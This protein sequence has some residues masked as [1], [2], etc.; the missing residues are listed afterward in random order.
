MH[1]QQRQRQQ[2]RLGQQ[3]Q[4][5]IEANFIRVTPSNKIFFDEDQPKKK[6]LWWK[7]YKI[8]VLCYAA[9]SHLFSFFPIEAAKKYLCF[10]NMPLCVF[11]WTKL[12]I[13]HKCD[14]GAQK[15]HDNEKTIISKHF[16]LIF[17]GHDWCTWKKECAFNE[18]IFLLWW[19]TGKRKWCHWRVKHFFYWVFSMKIRIVKH[20]FCYYQWSWRWRCGCCW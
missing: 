15:K 18:I 12:D 6:K 7:S 13:F 8:I 4:L 11:V 17:C 14:D 19:S 5:M 1:H 20:F 9:S 16:K 3:H 10:T 2:Q